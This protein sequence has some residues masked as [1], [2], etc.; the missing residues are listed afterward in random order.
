MLKSMIFV[1][2]SP[3]FERF[4]KI[5]FGQKYINR[6]NLCFKVWYLCLIHLISK[7]FENYNFWSQTV[8][9]A[10]SIKFVHNLAEVKRFEWVVNIV[11]N[12]QNLCL[13]HMI[14]KCFEKYNFWS[15]T[16]LNDSK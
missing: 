13:V 7:D 4:W 1:P 2:N 16:V 14:S 6:S 3:D 9:N 11:S 15:K 8:L 12:A 10:Q 5:I